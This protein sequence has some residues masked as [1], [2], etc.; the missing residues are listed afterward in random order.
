MKLKLISCEVF[1]REMCATVA[2][3]PNQVDVEFLPKGL[4]DIGQVGMSGR[5]Q[6][7]VDKVDALQYE[8]II[9]GYGLCNNGLAG[10]TARSLP[11]VLPRGH[12]CITLFLGSKE[13]YLDYFNNHPGVYFKTS[14]WIERGEATGE[15][16]QMS[17]QRMAG[18][19]K[20]YDE[21]V[22][23]YGEENAQYLYE[24]LYG[25]KNYG[26]ITY[27]EMGIEPDDRFEQSAKKTAEEKGWQ[28]KK[29][30]GDMRLIEKL[31]NGDWN[32]EEFL[33]VQPGHRIVVDYSDPVHIVK[34][35]QAP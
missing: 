9:L 6:A 32:E 35:E 27:I 18:L 1:F 23:K 8:A 26:Q 5:M 34:T 30:R 25:Y 4:H 11:L 19:D 20:S 21:L 15:L 22:E 7:A 31:V 12:D 33:V 28:F 29:E 17:I 2:R 13:R 24:Q 14:G 3:S 16:S 10:L